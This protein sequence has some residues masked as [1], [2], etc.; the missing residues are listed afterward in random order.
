MAAI[1]LN[2]QAAELLR[3][4]QAAGAEEGFFWATTFRRYQVQ[5][6][7]LQQLEGEIK[8]E[9]PRADLLRSYN[10]TASAANQTA[11]TLLTILERS[12]KY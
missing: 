8:A 9:G 1:D 2:A 12:D 10:S 6:T 4:A 3:R 5:M 11:A 7:V